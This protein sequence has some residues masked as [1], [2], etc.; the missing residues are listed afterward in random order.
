MKVTE[1][2]DETESTVTNAAQRE[3]ENLV[4]RFRWVD[5]FLTVVEAD[6][7]ANVD[8]VNFIKGVLSTL[9]VYSPV[10]NNGEN[11]VSFTRKIVT[12]KKYF[13]ANRFEKKM[14]LV[15]VL[16]GTNTLKRAV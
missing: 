7:S 4:V 5:G 13:I 12:R 10:P 14:F 1:T 15:C 9:Q 16:R 6:E 8:H 3:L 2:R 11:I